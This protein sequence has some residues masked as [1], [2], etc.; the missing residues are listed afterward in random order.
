MS[1][2]T[3]SFLNAMT[4]LGVVIV[5]FILVVGI[6]LGIM[7][8]A[9]AFNKKYDPL[10]GLKFNTTEA[11]VISENGG[12]A[13]LTVT[14]NTAE[15]SES[16][17]VISD[18]TI[19]TEI[20]LTVRPNKTG[21]GVENTII[22]VPKTV[23]KGEQFTITAKCLEDGYN[24]G[25]IC[26]IYAVTKDMMYRVAEPIEVKVD[27]PVESISIN[28]TDV[29]S[30]ETIN[31]EERQFI[32]QDKAQLSVTVEPARSIYVFGNKNET[33]TITY[34][35]GKTLYFDVDDDNVLNVKYSDIS[36]DSTPCTT[37]T[38]IEKV[39]AKI[40]KYSVS[41]N[42]TQVSTA[43]DVRMFPLQ[44]E[45]IEIG[46]S[47]YTDSTSSFDIPLFDNKKVSL[48]YVSGDIDNLDV[49]LKP[50]NARNVLDSEY[51]PLEK[52]M[53]NLEISV[54]ITN[55]KENIESALQ[56]TMYREQDTN[57]S[58]WQV[59]A[60]RL[61]ESGEEAFLT[62]KVK[63]NE[64]N[65]ID[66]FT[67]RQKINITKVDV[68]SFVYK[69]AG[70]NEIG[71]EQLSLTIAKESDKDD[72][73]VEPTTINCDI[74]SDS[75][76]KKV[77]NFIN[78]DEHTNQNEVCSKI[79]DAN[80]NYLLN[81]GEKSFDVSP[82]GAGSVT[83]SSY[84][85]RTNKD[86]Q[87]VDKDYK[88]I[89]TNAE[90]VENDSETYV[91]AS[92]FCLADKLANA[93]EGDYIVQQT[94][95]TFSVKVIEK[96]TS[97]TVY[98][99]SEFNE[100]DKLAND[101]LIMGTTPTNAVSLY[102]KPNSSLAIPANSQSGTYA[103]VSITEN[104]ESTT[105]TI[106][107]LPQTLTGN[108]NYYASSG[109]AFNSENPYIRYFKYEGLKTTQ[110]LSSSETVRN[111]ELSWNYSADTYSK[112]ITVT[113]MNI[114]ID[115]ITINDTNDTTGNYQAETFGVTWDSS[116][117]YW[118]WNLAVSEV[119]SVTYKKAKESDIEGETE[120]EDIVYYR[121]NY[122][123][124]KGNLLS[125]P[126]CKGIADI[127]SYKNKYG[128]NATVI[129]NAPSSSGN[130]KT[131]LYLFNN[132][133]FSLTVG[134]STYNSVEDVMKALNSNSITQ[135]DKKSLWSALAEQMDNTTNN[136]SQYASIKGGELVIQNAIP[137]G[138]SLFL[139]YSA[140]E[141]TYASAVGKFLPI[142][143]KISY[144]WPTFTSQIEGVSDYTSENGNKV[145]SISA[146]T[147][148]EFKRASIYSTTISYKD[149]NST[150]QTTDVTIDA[151]VDKSDTLTTS[152]TDSD[153][154]EFMKFALKGDSATD[155]EHH[156]TIKRSIKLVSMSSSEW[157][158][159]EKD[160]A[161]NLTKEISYTDYNLGTETIIFKVAST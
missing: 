118:R 125:T 149:I 152:I 92:S 153:S 58:Y 63:D 129:I 132:S 10:V 159:L 66:S 121:L 106:F 19:D 82:K 150:S 104:V 32:Y 74:G 43:K 26:Y 141:K 94:L 49:F 98:T 29:Y 155:T 145:Y 161:G 127:T 119:D 5:G 21:F 91:L 116:N 137:S 144:S 42:T 99:S 18:N 3:E 120:Y 131:S 71:G 48:Q 35:S 86:G 53:K 80:D 143:V 36:Y 61:L 136:A 54:E 31:F 90:E 100:E 9:G 45:S 56:S 115:S 93:N 20:E 47:A 112:T 12:T 37:P 7:L 113:A 114:P 108:N 85:V 4:I 88:I 139:I 124:S 83:I 117:S 97:L 151:E 44:L 39:T 147:P 101:K 140:D 103:T 68:N 27:V 67:K 57:N 75:T 122:G 15:I 50:I 73:N 84:L 46:N 22:E 52:M 28:A 96:L 25:G 62:V 146:S 14:A 158:K 72:V 16:G 2:K 138:N 60:N 109:E 17:S 13:K 64:D 135:D 128:D 11:I 55:S 70:G 95:G 105:P 33:K 111:I 51:N 78:T 59:S 107:G 40:S 79:I 34:S 24:K 23:K 142:G 30:G 154:G 148:L 81:G 126:A 110:T 65:Y 156:V 69:N 123:S 133:G 1:E 87:P 157:G 130:I 8:M 134:S 38:Q 102:F 76:F 77:V 160:S 41:S 89:T 6:A